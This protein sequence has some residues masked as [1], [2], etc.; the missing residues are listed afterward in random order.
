MTLSKI[1]DSIKI[2]KPLTGNSCCGNQQKNK[3]IT[4]KKTIKKHKQKNKKRVAKLENNCS[5]VKL[6]TIKLFSETVKTKIVSNK[7]LIDVFMFVCL[8]V[9]LFVPL[10]DCLF[11]WLYVYMSVGLYVCTFVCLHVSMF[12]GSYIFILVLFNADTVEAA[13]WN[14]C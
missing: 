2:K 3:T 5:H 10:Y 4:L 6:D 14:R 1:W 11:V 12:V 9:C 7:F 8:D 13:L